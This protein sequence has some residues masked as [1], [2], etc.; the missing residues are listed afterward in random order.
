MIFVQDAGGSRREWFLAQSTAPVLRSMRMPLQALT[1][2]AG[3]VGVAATP[4]DVGAPE[5]AALEPSVADAMTAAVATRMIVRDGR[6]R[7]RPDMGR[8]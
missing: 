2:G 6:W 1:A 8:V 7:M 3:V 5:C 4:A